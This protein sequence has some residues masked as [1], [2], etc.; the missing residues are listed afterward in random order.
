MNLL[1]SL[2]ADEAHLVAQFHQIRGKLD[3]NKQLQEWAN[4]QQEEVA[5]VAMEEE[6]CD[7]NGN[8]NARVG[9]IS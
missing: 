8:S 9:M 7:L 6:A 5:E 1:E 2:K 4:K 3:Y